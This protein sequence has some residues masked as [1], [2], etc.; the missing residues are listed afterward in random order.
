ML[1]R[2]KVD[3]D[4][5]G[6]FDKTISGLIDIKNQ[7]INTKDFKIHDESTA[8]SNV[9]E[10]RSELQE[11]KKRLEKAQKDA[12]ELS[13]MYET[14]G[15]FDKAKVE[16]TL[17]N[18]H[19]LNVQEREIVISALK[20][21]AT[22]KSEELLKKENVDTS[23]FTTKE[24]KEHKKEVKALKNAYDEAQELVEEKEKELKKFK[25]NF[26]KKLKKQI[27]SAE[28][29]YNKQTLNV[30]KE[31]SSAQEAVT[32]AQRKFNDALEAAGYKS[33]DARGN[34]K[35]GEYIQAEGA[36][37]AEQVT[38][39]AT[40]LVD[41]VVKEYIKTNF[42]KELNYQIDEKGTVHIFADDGDNRADYMLEGF[43]DAK[44]G[45]INL[46]ATKK[47]PKKSATSTDVADQAIAKYLSAKETSEIWIW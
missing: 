14:N 4:G 25:E 17:R 40:R 8:T 5:D 31:Y 37:K 15:K 35:K 42:G 34:Y 30:G 47:A 29:E 13:K 1:F 43:Y 6:I 24:L 18:A 32:K 28:K 16:N 23:N 12:A 11:A 9:N 2:S 44:S 10:Y 33:Q 45:K 19:Q 26:E 27:E 20:D 7:V 41:S 22:I 38:V 46:N 3:V 21:N 39:K 36:Q